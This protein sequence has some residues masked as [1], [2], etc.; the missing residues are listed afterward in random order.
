MTQTKNLLLTTFAFLSLTTQ[1]FNKAMLIPR[2][3]SVQ[4]LHRHTAKFCKNNIVP[5]N[6]ERDRK[7]ITEIAA[8]HL[9]M[10]MSDVTPRNKEEILQQI[11]NGLDNNSTISKVYLFNGQPIGFINY[12]INQPWVIAQNL[13]IKSNAHINF[14][15]VKDEHH[16]KG[17]GTALLNHALDDLNRRSIHTVTLIT[18]DPNLEKYYEKFGFISGRYSKYTGCTPFIKR[19]QP[20]P[21]TLIYSAIQ[22]W[23]L[24]NKE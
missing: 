5:Y 19:L 1:F 12:Y 8:Q 22:K 4:S 10:L 17:A 18:T 13:T 2:K 9:S 20:H 24:K 21:T 3:T 6:S 14:L 16:G 11:M 15:A 7:I 23:F